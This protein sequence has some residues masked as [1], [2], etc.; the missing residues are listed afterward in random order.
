MYL[1]YRTYT[2]SVRV[3]DFFL[4]GRQPLQTSPRGKQSISGRLRL[5]EPLHRVSPVIY[6]TYAVGVSA[7][8]RVVLFFFCVSFFALASAKNDTQEHRKYLAA[9][10]LNRF[11]KITA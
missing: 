1:N 10:G 8:G 11:R 9:A 7:F 6:M 3:Q 4:G 5:P 2:E